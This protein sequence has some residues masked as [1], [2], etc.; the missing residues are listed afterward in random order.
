MRSLILSVSSKNKIKKCLRKVDTGGTHST[1]SSEMYLDGSATRTDWQRLTRL[2]SFSI[3]I[4]LNLI[5]TELL[6]FKFL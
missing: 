5:F 3:F 4:Y 2:S 1:K 6:L